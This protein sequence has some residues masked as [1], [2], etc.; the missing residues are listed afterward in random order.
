M[1]NFYG[2]GM[3]RLL[4]L[5]FIGGG[6][7]SGEVHTARFRLFQAPGRQNVALE[8]AADQIETGEDVGK[9]R[10]GGGI[11]SREEGRQGEQPVGPWRAGLCAHR[12]TGAGGDPA[13]IVRGAGDGAAVEIQA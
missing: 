11:L 1:V 12:A 4:T 5:S 7:K 3:L 13:Q 9:R 2:Q 8:E 6:S 10:R